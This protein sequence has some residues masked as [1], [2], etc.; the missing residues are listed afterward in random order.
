[1]KLRQFNKGGVDA[2]RGI[3][4]MLRKDP[5]AP[6]DR[7]IL[8][9][10]SLTEEVPGG[11]D[12]VDKK[13]KT[14]GE[15]GRYLHALLD[16][17]LTPDEIVSNGG[18]WSWLSLFF[19][20]SVCPPD[21]FGCRSVN[22]ELYYVYNPKLWPDY[23]RHFLAMSWKI[24]L[25]HKLV[26]S[27]PISQFDRV[28]QSVMGDLTLLRIPCIFDVLDHLYWDESIQEIRQNIVLDDVMRG[29]LRK[30]FPTVIRQLEKTYDLQSLAADQ[31]VELLGNE[32]VFT[33]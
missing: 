28:S 2:F 32:F 24:P 10:D 15:A 13:F 29:D 7:Q 16:P 1:M 26:S 17:I 23:N 6:I 30:R 9:N 18:L 12:V 27:R 33:A 19:F 25:H 14:K 11:G 3:I 21:S 20:D 22:N 5:L 4:Q 8:K 31:L